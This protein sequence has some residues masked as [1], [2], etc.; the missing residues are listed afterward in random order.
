LKPAIRKGMGLGDSNKVLMHFHGASNSEESG[1]AIARRTFKRLYWQGY[2]GHNVAV[3][4]ESDRAKINY[5]D[6][7]LSAL[8]AGN[9]PELAGYVTGLN[10]NGKQISMT[11]H[12]C[13]NMVVSRLLQQCGQGVVHSFAK[14]QS[15]APAAAYG[16][17]PP[18]G[19]TFKNTAIPPGYDYMGIF[20]DVPG[21]VAKFTNLYSYND[22]VLGG[23]WELNEGVKPT[24]RGREKL[25][26]EEDF[27]KR[28][29]QEERPLLYWAYLYTTNYRAAGRVTL[30]PN[31]NVNVGNIITGHSQMHGDPLCNVW[32]YFERLYDAIQ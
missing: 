7:V 5:N 6:N 10:G 28:V 8:L 16:T 24:Q 4:W 2:D 9:N 11:A 29:R 19:G 27:L 15:A 21:K 22:N 3:L 1:D 17:T 13:G 23:L 14:M 31:T 25:I 32:G 30:V 26:T 20:A 18:G 12:S